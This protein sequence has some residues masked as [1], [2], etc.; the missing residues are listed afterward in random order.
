MSGSLLP[1]ITYAAQNT[2]LYGQGGGGATVPAN[3][4]ISTLEAYPI[5]NDTLSRVSIGFQPA[6]GGNPV[7]E[8]LNMYQ[9]ST[10]DTI[11]LQSSSDSLLN[12]V[13]DFR[14]YNKG[15]G[16]ESGIA[17]RNGPGNPAANASVRFYSTVAG[18]AFPG[19]IVSDGLGF[20]T[21]F[22][23][24]STFTTNLQTTNINGSAYP[25]PP[26]ENLTVSTLTASTIATGILQTT[27]VLNN[28]LA[29]G[30]S[31]M[32]F[33]STAT[34]TFN[35]SQNA[36]GS[37]LSIASVASGFKGINLDSATGNTTMTGGLI[38]PNITTSL[39]NSQAFTTNNGAGLNVAILPQGGT[40][41]TRTVLSN[42]IPLVAGGSYRIS[43]EYSATN[44][45]T[46]GGT[47]VI[48][49]GLAPTPPLLFIDNLAL[50]LTTVVGFQ[51]CM[52]RNTTG[53]TV[54]VTVEGWNTS[55]T[56]ATNLAGSVGFL[57]EYLGQLS[58]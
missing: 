37:T 5:P 20:N 39:I 24:G 26:S 27:P 16:S 6:G 46:D 9:A 1:N 44:P 21:S 18:T 32:S 35:I 25:A 53:A 30:G 55:A 56:G 4:T 38:A 7:A 22:Y 10:I 31:S 42:P 11:F 52:V 13:S 58:I 45:Q 34:A 47:F 17:H 3:L 2:P 49:E 28:F 51:A 50:S 29:V 40:I 36:V 12:L 19:V 54:N 8:T 23:N 48:L 15:D 41:N 14:M 33:V 43:W 57:V